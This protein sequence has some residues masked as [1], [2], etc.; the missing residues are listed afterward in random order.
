MLSYIDHIHSSLSK[1][2]KALPD[3]KVIVMTPDMS[4][5]EV[6]E[7]MVNLDKDKV[8]IFIKSEEEIHI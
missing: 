7:I 1:A 3:A 6:S 8:V 4:F 5:W 2:I